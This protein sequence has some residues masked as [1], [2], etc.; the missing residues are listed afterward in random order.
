MDKDTLE[1]KVKSIFDETFTQNDIEDVPDIEDKRLTHGATGLK[2]EF[3]FLY[4]DL[5]GSSAYTDEHR[6][7]TI[8]KIYKAFH[9]CAVESIKSKSGRIRS[10]DGDR[11][12]GV[13]GGKRK[14]NNAVEAAKLIIGC[15]QDI[16]APMVKKKYGNDS[17][18]IG[19]GIA[20][21]D[22]LVVKAG[23]G[24]DKNNRDLVWIGDP[25]NLGA[26]L[27]DKA[28]NPHSIYICSNTKGKLL[29][30]NEF[31]TKNGQKKSKWEIVVTK[32]AD[33][34]VVV[35]KSSY[36]THIK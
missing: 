13:F 10:F 30:K 21:G 2:G 28:S 12:L 16:L 27:S 19:V 32:F 17:F 22:T 35:Y 11:V 20:T 6:L 18:E 31:E 36:F 14:V 25:P 9:H 23:V 29:E 7:Q 5:R 34:S 1:K 8:A 15:E 24:Y 3:A 4:A 33:K 26:K